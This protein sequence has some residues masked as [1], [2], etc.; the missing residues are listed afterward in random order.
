MCNESL[1]LLLRSAIVA[2]NSYVA[3][4]N[5]YLSNNILTL[6]EVVE[7]RTRTT[8]STDPETGE[9]TT[10]EEDY[11]YYILYRVAQK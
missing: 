1:L 11:E 7:I 3:T 10:E 2:S 8:S 9:T 5:G 6:T 4:C